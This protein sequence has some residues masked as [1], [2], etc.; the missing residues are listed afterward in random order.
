[1]RTMAPKGHDTRTGFDSGSW[2]SPPPTL[3]PPAGLEL[4]AHKSTVEAAGSS[5]VCLVAKQPTRLC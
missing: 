1:M 4:T 2:G 5:A 3:I